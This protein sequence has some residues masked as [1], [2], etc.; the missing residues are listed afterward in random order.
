MSGLHV[1]NAAP[2]FSGPSG[3][4]PD[5]LA[6]SARLQSAVL[7]L[8]ADFLR[9][10]GSGVDYEACRLS[11]A[12]AAF[13]DTAR[14]LQAVE[15]EALGSEAERRSLFINLYNALTIHGLLAAPVLP[16]SPQKLAS[17]WDVTAYQFGSRTLTLN[18]IE[19][20][21]LRGN[22]AHPAGRAP[23]WASSDPRCSLA[24]PLD[25]RIH[26]ALNCGAKSCPPIR[27]YSP[28]NLEFGLARAAGSFLENSVEVRDGV[29][30][31]SSLLNWYGSDFG[32]TQAEVL[33]Y[34]ARCLPPDSSKRAALEQ[35]LAE[36]RDAPP[37]L[38]ATLWNGVVARALPTFMPRGPISVQYA[39]YDWSLNTA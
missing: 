8:Q 9:E 12:F 21:I 37:G 11:P 19:H 27:V 25:A 29:V 36:T 4:P 14:E 15:V 32:A 7:G 13:V 33:A 30:M 38:G 35:L 31:L 28:K 2:A 26:F 22:R 39:P 5:G 16:S 18:D 17:F 23:H 24:L 3:P 1:L 20:G 10:D 6:L 34:V